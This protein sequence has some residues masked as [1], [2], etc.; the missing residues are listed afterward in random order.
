M[1]Y[2]R[3]LLQHTLAQI[4]GTDFTASSVVKSVTVL[5]AIR[6]IKL[7]WD[8]VKPQTITNC[9]KLCGSLLQEQ[10]C[11]EDPFAGLEEQPPVGSNDDRARLQELMDQLGSETT[12]EEYMSTND[13]LCTCMNFESSDEWR[14][15][16]RSMVC[17]ESPPAAK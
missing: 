1:H 14:D 15:E 7:A 4:E 11:S 6:W 9:F 12:A 16:L 2:C 17:D 8:E 3:L 10:E 5:M 13:D